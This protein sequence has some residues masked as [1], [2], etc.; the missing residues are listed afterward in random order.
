[1]EG[2]VG[3]QNVRAVTCIRVWPLSCSIADT[4]P[5]LPRVR[6]IGGLLSSLAAA[7]LRMVRAANSS[8]SGVPNSTERCRREREK[9]HAPYNGLSRLLMAERYKRFLFFLPLTA[10]VFFRPISSLSFDGSKSNKL[11]VVTCNGRK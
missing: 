11:I 8:L 10:G 3:S 6:I 1:M 2:G 7:R 5:L 4:M 9:P